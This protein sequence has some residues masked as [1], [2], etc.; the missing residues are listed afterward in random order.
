MCGGFYEHFELQDGEYN[1]YA[2]KNSVNLSSRTH[3]LPKQSVQVRSTSVSKRYWASKSATMS[4][5]KFEDG[6]TVEPQRFNS[7]SRGR[8]PPSCP[9][10]RACAQGLR[11]EVQYLSFFLPR[12]S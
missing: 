10:S 9:C 7:N 6:M 5:G 2:S 1:E 11:P 4:Q 12:S 3:I 8:R